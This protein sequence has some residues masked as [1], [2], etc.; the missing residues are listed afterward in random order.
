M[1]VLRRRSAA[2]RFL[3]SRVRIPLKVWMF[4]SVFVV[5]C[6]GSGLCDELIARSEES[7]RVCVCLIVCDVET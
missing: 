3:G 7:C 6:V 5:C 2:A 4:V 1:A